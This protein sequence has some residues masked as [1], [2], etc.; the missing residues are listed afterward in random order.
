MNHTDIKLKE[1]YKET[2]T[3]IC[4]PEA[5]RKKIKDIATEEKKK[6]KVTVIRK[7]AVAVAVL[8][9]L[10][11]GSNVVAYATT[12]STWVKSMVVY[13]I[14]PGTKEWNELGSVQ[15][16]HEALRIPK[17]VLNKMSKDELIQAVL[18]YPFLID[19]FLSSYKVEIDGGY[20]S[21]PA[22]ESVYENCDAL[23][24]LFSR[25]GGKKA[26]K[27]FYE[28]RMKTEPASAQEEIE[29]DALEAI[30]KVLID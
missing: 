3:G 29:N 15:E 22:V 21:P 16:K 10:F 19:I 6:T 24:E 25:W 26:L 20:Y 17:E 11:M 5:L 14:Q 13:L 18:N 12:G 4:A 28:E 30:I 1:E 27:E 7:V 23:Q 8:L 9:V 2:F